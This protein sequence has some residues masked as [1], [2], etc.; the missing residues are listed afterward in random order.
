MKIIFPATVQVT[1]ADIA[2]GVPYSPTESP[3]ALAMS[4]TFPGVRVSATWMG[5]TL[6]A[7]L[8]SPP[9]AEVVEFIRRFDK[10]CAGEP[11]EFKLE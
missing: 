4:R 1:E 9:P 10:E 11:F 5:L 8:V 6:G 2:A 3:V 7:V